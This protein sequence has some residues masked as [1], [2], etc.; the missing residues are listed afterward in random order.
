MSYSSKARKAL[1]KVKQ[2]AATKNA[3]KNR[4]DYDKKLSAIGLQWQGCVRLAAC[5]A[6]DN[7]IALRLVR[8]LN[9]LP[10]KM[11]HM[12]AGKAVLE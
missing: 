4:N 11:Q 7:L 12:G 1:G 3:Q 9:A 5:I 6:V 10:L 2:S 8:L